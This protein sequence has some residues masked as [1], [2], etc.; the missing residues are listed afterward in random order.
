MLLAGILILE[1]EV[2]LF[3]GKNRVEETK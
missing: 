2:Y 3:V 1:F